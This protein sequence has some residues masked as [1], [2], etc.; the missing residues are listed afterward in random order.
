MHPFLLH[1][2]MRISTVVF[3]GTPSTSKNPV[4]YMEK[5]FPLGH[6]SYLCYHSIAGNCRDNNEQQGVKGRWWLCQHCCQMCLPIYSLGTRHIIKERE[7]GPELFILIPLCIRS[8]WIRTKTV[9]LL[10][11]VRIAHLTRHQQ[12]SSKLT[13]LMCFASWSVP[14]IKILVSLGLA[15]QLCITHNLLNQRTKKLG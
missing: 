5:R 12:F 15:Q 14:L 4:F 2:S 1:H 3:A 6:I 11:A 10:I 9:L 8:H 7:S 13:K